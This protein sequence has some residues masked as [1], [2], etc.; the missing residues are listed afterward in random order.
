M[1]GVDDGVL[2]VF[3]ANEEAAQEWRDGQGDDGDR[4]DGEAEPEYKGVPLPCP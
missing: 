4:H 2:V 1:G 3:D